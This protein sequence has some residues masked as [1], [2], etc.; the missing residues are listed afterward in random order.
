MGL[1]CRYTGDDGR[2]HIDDWDLKSNEEHHVF[3]VAAGVTSSTG[4]RHHAGST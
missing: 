1:Y 4:I 2:S 3:H